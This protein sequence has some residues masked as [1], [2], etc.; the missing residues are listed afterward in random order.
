MPRNNHR[1][2]RE[3]NA[4]KRQS[5]RDGLQG[6]TPRQD[7]PIKPQ[8]SS[9]TGSSERVSHKWRDMER[10]ATGESGELPPLPG[11]Q[12]RN[13]KRKSGLGSRAI[14]FGAILLV[15]VAA[16]LILP[17]S[18]ILDG[19]S[20]PTPT[21]VVA[22]NET[23]TADVASGATEV[24]TNA[25]AETV[26]SDFLVCIDPGHGGWDHGRERMDMSVFGPPWFYE[27]EV[28]LSMSFL[29]RDELESRG[30][31]VVM[32]R[33][34][35]GAVNWQNADVN[36]DGQILSDT[37]EGQIAGMRDEM[38]ARINICNDAAADIMISIHLNGFDDQSVSGYE[39]FYNTQRDFATQNQDLANFVY[40]E[41]S[42]GF[43][44]SGYEANGR[45][46]TDDLNLSA[47]THDFGSEQFLIMI[48]P[49]V[50]KPEYT[51]TPTTM[52]G[53]IIETL[54]VS[55]TND[56]NFILNPVNQQNL[57]SSWA[58]GIEN[59]RKRYGDTNP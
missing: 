57:A 51:I 50:V 32:T 23:A 10:G 56:A 34:T 25:P 46:T 36:G 38:Q 40:R 43:A 19:E 31:A 21:P 27:S 4:R 37:P 29:L 39:V 18:G 7:T 47:E 55:N 8:R 41:M 11:Q 59:Y 58:D 48:G 6:S 16:M 42:V 52:P 17:L 30:I 3:Q 15:A 33:E 13:G 22:V 12:L 1:D 24:P 2:E 28:T 45:G 9:P 5:W 54:F 49:E 14:L 20:E 44:E 26:Q 35:G 53:V